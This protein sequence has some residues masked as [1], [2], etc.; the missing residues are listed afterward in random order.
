MA[1]KET[2]STKETHQ[3]LY[4]EGMSKI[5]N[6]VEV[7]HLTTEGDKENCTFQPNLHREK[8]EKGR[9]SSLAPIYDR[10]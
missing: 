2:R 1:L 10:L 9:E 5:K 7:T 3:R 8:P 4:E 6:T